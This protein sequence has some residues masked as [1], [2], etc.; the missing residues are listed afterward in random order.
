MAKDLS[1]QDRMVGISRRGP[2][3]RSLNAGA[4]DVGYTGDLSFLT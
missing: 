1:L 4:L 3:P 2:D